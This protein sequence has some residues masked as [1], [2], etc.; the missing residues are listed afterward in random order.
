MNDRDE[1]TPTGRT[2]ARDVYLTA[3]GGVAL[4][5]ETL[6][7]VRQLQAQSR[8]KGTRR[9]YLTH[10]KTF[11]AWCEREGRRALPAEPITVAAYLGYANSLLGKDGKPFYAPDTLGYWLSSINKAHTTAGFTKPGLDAGVIATMEG[12]RRSNERTVDRKT[13]LLL[14]DLRR[15]L[16]EVDLN[17]WPH[18]VIGHRDWALMLMGFSGAFR[19]SELAGLQLRDVRL[20]AEDGLHVTLRKSKTDQEGKGMLKA[21]PFGSDP[22]TCPPCAFARWL[23]V[24]AAAEMG[25]PEVMAA[26]RAANPAVHICREPLPEL[27]MQEDPAAAPA[28]ESAG[29]RTLRLKAAAE[30]LPI[31]R[32]V[33]KN[34][35]IL[36]RPVSSNVVND[37]LKRRI[38]A[39]G[40]NPKVYGAHS[41]R[42]GFVTQAFRAGATH[43]EV[44]RQTGHKDV[45]SVE[46]YSIE[47]A[48]LLHNAV[49]RLGL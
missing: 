27:G 18:G 28:S 47:N 45:A 40:L 37:V 2:R 38:Q 20:H 10:W 6:L 29:E 36:M 22:M 16:S 24:L 8:S 31:F 23:R 33:M 43:H 46:I 14:G 7:V 30:L 5:S 44:M 39:V 19:R 1:I 21:L 48:P 32:P 41:L 11:E 42:S 12:I 25:R 26:V 3:S 4:P 17:S 15:T 13:P 34:G 35:A 49:T 9:A